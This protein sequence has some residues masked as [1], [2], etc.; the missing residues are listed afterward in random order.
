MHLPVIPFIAIY[1]GGH[2]AAGVDLAGETTIL[3]AV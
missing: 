3:S 1:Y 2:S